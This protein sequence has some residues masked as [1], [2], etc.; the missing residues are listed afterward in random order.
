MPRSKREAMNVYTWQLWRIQWLYHP[1]HF[2][3][4]LKDVFDWSAMND[5]RD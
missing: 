4:M 2:V 3:R 1:D 5:R